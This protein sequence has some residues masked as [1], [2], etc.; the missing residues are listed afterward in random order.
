[1]KIQ[2]VNI[3]RI[4][5]KVKELDVTMRL[6]NSCRLLPPGWDCS[7]SFCGSLEKL[8][9]IK[10]EMLLKINQWRDDKRMKNDWTRVRVGKLGI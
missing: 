9:Q 8:N 6:K 7:Q 1:M 3:Y 5:R 4:A 2:S 10:K